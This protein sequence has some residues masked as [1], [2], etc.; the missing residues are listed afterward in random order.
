MNMY[1]LF[2]F[3]NHVLGVFSKIKKG[4][5]SE[6]GFTQDVSLLIELYQSVVLIRSF[7]P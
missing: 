4:A 5:R 6:W 7:C 2:F 3:G 1:V